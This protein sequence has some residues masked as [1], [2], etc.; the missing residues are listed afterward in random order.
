M[1]E[2]READFGTCSSCSATVV[3]VRTPKGKKMPCDPELFAVRIAEDGP[4]TVVTVDGKTVRAERV[5]GLL[6]E[7]P[8]IPGRPV[9]LGRI[10]HFATCPNAARH[11]KGKAADG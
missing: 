10:S 7:T 6:S 3:W 1:A 2:Q 4:E 9:V 11:R 8:A 5:L